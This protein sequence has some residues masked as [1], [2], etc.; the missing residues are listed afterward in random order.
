MRR[1]YQ[2]WL[3]RIIQW[4]VRRFRRFA[5]NTSRISQRVWGDRNQTIAQMSG[6]T[7]IANVENFYLSPQ[8]VLSLQSFWETW[9]QETNPPFSLSLV[10]GGREESRDR[11]LSWLRGSPSPFTLQGDSTEEAIVFLAAV[12]QSLKEEERT[13]VLS[14]AVVV[15]GSTAWQTLVNSSKP[16]ILIA[17]LNQPEGTGQAIKLGHHV[18]IPVGRMGRGDVVLPRIVRNAAE[19]ALNEMGL[20]RQQTS[21]LATLARRSLSALRRKL[22]IA[23]GISHP[24]WAQPIAARQLLAPLLVSVWNDACPG[25]RDALSQLSGMPYEILQTSLVRWAHEPDPPL[26]RVGDIWMMAAQE[27]AWRLIARYLTTDDLQ[28]VERVAID[29][30]SELDP[31]FELPPEQRYTASIYGKVPTRSGHLRNG[32][33]ETLALMATLSSEIS[34]TP[35]R[36]SEAVAHKIVW[37]LLEQAKDNATLWASLAGQLP[38]LAEAAPGI[39]LKAVEAGLAGEPPILV[40]L[41]QDQTPNAAFMSSSPHTHLLWAL[42]TLAWNPDHLSSAALSLARLARLDPGG[43][44]TNRPI[45]SLRDIFICWHPNTNAPLDHRLRVLD[46]IRRHEPTVAWNLLMQLLPRHHSTV[47]PTHGTKWRDWVPDA[48]RTPTVQEYIDATNAILERL[49][50]DAQI[51]P[52]RWCNLIKSAGGMTP[53]QREIFLQRLA[54]ID[55]TSFSAKERVQIWHCLREETIRHRDFPAS[56]WAMPT[57]SVKRMEE[58]YTRFEPDEPITRHAWLFSY[59]VK[60]PGMITIPWNEGEAAVERLRVEALQH[61]LKS[62]GWKGI[63]SLVEQVKK[64]ALVGITLG[65][66]DLLPID[67]GEFL[68]DNL[69]VPEPWRDQMAHSFVSFCAHNLGES[70][71]EDCLLANSG[72]WNPEQYGNFLLCL[73]FSISLLDRIDALSKEIQCYFWSHIRHIDFFNAIYIDRLLNRLIEFERPHLAVV[74]ALPWAIKQ[75]PEIVS[76]ERIAKILEISV[77]ISPGVGFDIQSFA[78]HSAELLDYLE[79]SD[80]TQDRLAQLE[81]MYFK[82]HSDYRHPRM[83]HEELAQ[84]PDFFI[85]VLRCFYRAENE[86]QVEQTGEAIAFIDLVYKLLD[87]WYKMPG[88]Q[89]DNSVDAEALHQWVKRVR[90][91]AAACDRSEVADIHIGN[92]LAFSPRDP[93]GTWPHTAVR[94]LIEELINPIIEEGLSTQKLNNRGVTT[95]LITDGGA[96]E[97]VLVEQYEN[98]ATQTGDQWPQTAAMLRDMAN[99][100]RRCAVQEDQRAEMAQDFWR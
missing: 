82:I 96:Q 66:S 91:L 26:R 14:R 33:A 86:P 54:A 76:S 27:D 21:T 94:D 40:S 3:K 32:V 17:Q 98:W 29:T 8:D 20:N 45:R 78:Y 53:E 79:T 41:F 49:L 1:S 2:S 19:E 39:F 63:L 59:N 71:I 51:N 99:Q 28:R 64:P 65:R 70:W 35:N 84:N 73:P 89:A 92:I 83:L 43:A 93:D 4:L 36:T 5:N 25:D 18:F 48:R 77:R 50:S 11:V 56:D 72:T 24:A 12:V 60:L 97:Q 85:E 16:N 100:Y 10:I 38:L 62:Q 47:S 23:Q 7:A 58:I 52:I 46:I 34:F 87:S 88:V 67:L 13:K 30:L 69:G 61:I 15:N 68:Q 44:L 90:E 37:Q 57:E 42:E 74:N 55:P 31:A 95:R 9:S 6:G 75:A 80:L 81:W 22:A